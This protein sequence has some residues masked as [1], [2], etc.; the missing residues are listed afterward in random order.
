[1]P[2]AGLRLT[3]RGWLALAGTVALIV[4][5]TVL[6]QAIFLPS[7]EGSPALTILPPFRLGPWTLA[8]LRLSWA[9]AQYGLVQSLRLAALAVSGMLV[10]LSTSPE[11]LLAAL[12]ALR[13][14]AALAFLA[15]AGLRFLPAIAQEWLLV[16]QARRLR[17]YRPSMRQLLRPWRWL[18]MELALFLPLLALML[19]RS[20]TLAA[21]VSSRGFDPRQS[22]SH[23]MPLTL[24]R[25][26][27]I[28]LILMLIP[29]LA[30]VAI[31]LL[32]WLDRAHWLSLPALH[33]WHEMVARWL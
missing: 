12:T 14:P 11:R 5:G 7:P 22:P 27:G 8:G 1:M 4:W 24:R 33:N 20:A 29:A 2:L 3:W 15:A 21:S 31:K 23:G 19:R 13:L 16:R 28:A 26:E 30:L 32:Y 10:C 25:G 17:G 6:T 9:G 18:T